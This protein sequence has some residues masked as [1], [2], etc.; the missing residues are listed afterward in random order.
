MREDKIEIEQIEP[1][2]DFTDELSDEALDRAA[3]GA[4]NSA[5]GGWASRG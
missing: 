3:A 4:R 1:I 2:T 5:T